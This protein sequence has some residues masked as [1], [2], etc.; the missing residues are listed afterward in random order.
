MQFFISCCTNVGAENTHDL[1]MKKEMNLLLNWKLKY[2]A[3]EG[4]CIFSFSYQQLLV[5]D[6][7]ALQCIVR[8]KLTC[9][10]RNG[11]TVIMH[12][13]DKTRLSHQL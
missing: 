1:Q 3:S 6:F 9:F 7:A 4:D 2:A 8:W 5:A 11:N 10:I 13:Y 12:F